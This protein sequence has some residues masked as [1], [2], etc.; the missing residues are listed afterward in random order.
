MRRQTHATGR[1]PSL[2]A[3]RAECVRRHVGNPALLAWLQAWVLSGRPD[4]QQQRQLLGRTNAAARS[5]HWRRSKPWKC[6]VC[7]S[8]LECCSC[9]GSGGS[10]A[11][12]AG[13]G[14]SS[15]GRGGGHNCSERLRRATAG[16]L[17]PAQPFHQGG[18][19]LTSEQN[20]SYQTARGP[21]P[22]STRAA[23]PRLCM[24]VMAALQGSIQDNTHIYL[25]AVYAVSA[26]SD[27]LCWDARMKGS[28]LAL[29]ARSGARAAAG[30]VA[31][32]LAAAALGRRMSMDPPR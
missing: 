31:A 29:P 30:A 27:A 32:K 26:D 20:T 10:T 3:G 1:R 21:L 13:R 4:A 19:K 24:P 17:N 18:T 8:R 16:H 11:R 5:A 28:R 9:G 7:Q 2:Q 12:A 15:S 25:A 22:Q 23:L 6:R 14:R